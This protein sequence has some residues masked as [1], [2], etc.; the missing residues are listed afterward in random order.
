[1]EPEMS[2]GEGDNVRL[3]MPNAI[4][5]DQPV[6]V[7]LGG[8]T[9]THFFLGRG[10]TDGDLLVGTPTTL[11]VGEL[12]EQGA[13]PSFEDCYREEWAD[14]LRHSSALPHR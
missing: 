9:A 3:V 12:V 2:T 1:M 11:Y 14:A 13:H 10:H 4:V 5:K 8:L 7:D 6:L